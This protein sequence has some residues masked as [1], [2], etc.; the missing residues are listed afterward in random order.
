MED[1]VPSRQAPLWWPFHLLHAFLI[2]LAYRLR[3]S[4]GHRMTSAAKVSQSRG[5][6]R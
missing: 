1:G 6:Q 4:H 2:V 5:A 3:L